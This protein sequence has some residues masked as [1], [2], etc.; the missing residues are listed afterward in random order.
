MTRPDMIVAAFYRTSIGHVRVVPHRGH[1]PAGDR[2]LL[3][4]DKRGFD[5]HVLEDALWWTVDS[6]HFLES[7][8]LIILLD[9]FLGGLGHNRRKL[10]LMLV[11]VVFVGI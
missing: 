8:L 3:A 2:N 5:R 1:H 11:L 6:E 10:P 9:E 4:V 7:L